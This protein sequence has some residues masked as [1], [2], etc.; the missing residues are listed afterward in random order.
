MKVLALVT[1]AFGS[2]GGIAQYNRDFLTAL[3]ETGA[4]VVVQPRYAAADPPVPKN[5]RQLAPRAG[6]SAY[7]V[8]VLRSALASRFDV[9]FCGHLYM[10]ALARMAAGMRRS[11]L[12]IQLHG[13][14]AWTPPRRGARA[15]F[16]QGDLV[17]AVSRFTRSAALRWSHLPPERIVVIP[18]TV[19]DVFEPG[20]RVAARTA[21]G[22]TDEA[23]LLSVGRL[24]PRER[25]K[26]Q[27]RVI[28]ALPGLIA[29]GRRVAYVVAGDGG[30][31]ARLESLA[32]ERGVADAVRFV[33]EVGESG[34]PALYRAADLFVLPSTGE[35][36][37]IVYLEAMASGTPALG[38]RAG[39]APDALADGRLGTLATAEGLA[40]AIAAG[41]DGPE[42]DRSALS[43]EVVARFGREAF[44]RAVARLAVR[45]EEVA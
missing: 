28:D 30:D 36:F 33:G 42:V 27:D 24:D 31:R 9:I 43:A 14:E 8:A 45:L 21:L 22:F 12:V 37:G 20:D 7:G 11:R 38:L 2:S 4:E 10:A 41:L 16:E 26:G 1:D 19:R 3:S 29:G 35:G 6:R 13:I 23:V 5:I 34:L 40:A 32:R 44:R 17:L 25:Y 39:G 15:A 18:N